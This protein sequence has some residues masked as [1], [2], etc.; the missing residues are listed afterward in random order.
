MRVLGLHGSEAWVEE[1]SFP[2]TRHG[3]ELAGLSLVPVPVDEEGID[4]E[5][6]LRVAP[7]AALVVITPGQ[8][9]PLGMTLS[10]ARRLRLLDWAA[11]QE[12]WVIEDDYLSELQLGGRAAP[13]LASLDRAGRVIHIG[14]FSKTIAPALRLGFVVAPLQLASRFAEV[15]ACLAPAPIPAVQLATAE[16][17]RDGHYMR[18]LRRTKRLYSAQSEALLHY[19]QPRAKG[20]RIETA[21]LAALLQLPA[22]TADLAVVRES[23]AFGLAPAPLSIWYKSPASAQPGLLLGVST[24]PLQHIASAC[25]RLLEIVERHT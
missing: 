5:H 23:L 20:I 9:A 25:D 11:Q 8:Q 15:A 6:G 21:G 2:L 18:H 16:F 24:A 12:R 13:S 3:L 14:S 1:P 7:E 17:M 19:L 4:V 10:L 22:G